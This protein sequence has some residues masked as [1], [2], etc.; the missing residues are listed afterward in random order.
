MSVVSLLTM[1]GPILRRMHAHG[2]E[3]DEVDSLVGESVVLTEAIA[4]NGK[5]KGELRGTSWTVVNL[6]DAE[7]SSGEARPVERVDG[8]TLYVR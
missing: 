5:G 1:R 2:F 8:L 4:P 3:A 6:G 7:L